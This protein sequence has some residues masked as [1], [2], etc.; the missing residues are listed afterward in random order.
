MLRSMNQESPAFR[1]GE[2]QEEIT[3]HKNVEFDRNV[4]KYDVYTESTYKDRKVEKGITP[5]KYAML[6]GTFNYDKVT[7]KKYT[8][9]H[10]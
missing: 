6:D 1:H 10:K 9:L 7:I 3:V 4:Y 2:C 5:S 8:K